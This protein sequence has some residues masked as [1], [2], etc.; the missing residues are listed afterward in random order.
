MDDKPAGSNTNAPATRAAV[1]Q[2][3]EE[4]LAGRLSDAALAKWAFDSFY[5]M[6]LAEEDLEDDTPRAEAD[7]LLAEAL[8]A[9]MFGDDPDFRLSE[10]ELRDL[11]A[12]LTAQG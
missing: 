12:R 4:R 5:A 6:E 7:A 10:A 11:A 9:L 8:D 1:A 3:I 2:R